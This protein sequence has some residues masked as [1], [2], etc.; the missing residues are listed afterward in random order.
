MAPWD[1]VG[2]GEN[3]NSVMDLW[4]QGYSEVTVSLLSNSLIY[5]GSQPLGR[6]PSG[7]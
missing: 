6:D 1:S 2:K 3:W 7:G 5:L 4:E